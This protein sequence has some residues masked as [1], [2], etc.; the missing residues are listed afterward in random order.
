MSAANPQPSDKGTTPAS[1]ID[2]TLQAALQVC[3]DHAEDLLASARLV[4]DGGSP[5]IAW[6]LAALALEEIGR[7][8]LLV[9]RKLA[10]ARPIPPAW[11]DK[12]LTNHEQKLFWALFGADF[13]STPLTVEQFRETRE[14]ATT[15][16]RARLAGLYVDVDDDGL[17]IPAE[18]IDPKD[19]R[20][21]IG[22]VTA[23]LEIAKKQTFRTDAREEDIELTDWFMRVVEDPAWRKFIFSGGSMTKRG[24]LGG[25][26]EW[27]VWVKQQ[28][29][30]AAAT[31]MTAA[32]NELVRVVPAQRT[33]DKWSMVLRV[34]T[35]SH[36]IPPKVLNLWN[37]NV[38]HIKLEM[39]DP[40]KKH[41]LQVELRLGDDVP[42]QGV[43]W[44]GDVNARQF[45]VALNIATG[46]FWWY[47]INKHPERYYESLTDLDSGA[48]LNAQYQQHALPFAGD[49]VLRESHLQYTSM[50]MSVLTRLTQ[51]QKTASLDAY[52]SGLNFLSLND[53][54]VRFD[55]DAFYAFCAS[56][57]G[58]MQVAADERTLL[59]AL[60][61]LLADTFPTS[62]PRDREAFIALATL[63]DDQRGRD[64][65]IKTVD[66][67]AAKSLC[68]RYFLSRIGPMFPVA[69]C[70]GGAPVGGPIDD[71]EPEPTASQA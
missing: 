60:P 8:E 64:P 56:L 12:H 19:V 70:T 41:D 9:V 34:V 17:R 54:M 39:R 4:A 13:L 22:L 48:A 21:L 32:Q 57:Q 25:G 66:I 68:D 61:E 55:A 44:W 26:R 47:H 18:A 28:Y 59:A 50:S 6:H 2:A 30:A 20:N 31:A 5:N 1:P 10:S 15:I 11:P 58:M 67:F 29:D 69:W 52:I 35:A 37:K 46:G 71:S 40:K 63:P 33:H 24:E 3:V 7:R 49:A 27:I 51:Q 36:Q 53:V 65:R 23:R 38:P 14:L 43:Y 45:I 42:L 16:H 62:S